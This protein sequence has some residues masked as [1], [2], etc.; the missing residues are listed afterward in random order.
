[1]AL[2]KIGEHRKR[3]CMT[4]ITVSHGEAVQHSTSYLFNSSCLSPKQ[5]TLAKGLYRCQLPPLLIWFLTSSPGPVAV[6]RSAVHAFCLDICLWRQ[7]DFCRR[8]SGFPSPSQVCVCLLD[9]AKWTAGAREGYSFLLITFVRG[10]L[11]RRDGNY[12]VGSEGLIV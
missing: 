7:K 6:S 9:L 8:F 4:V 3:C 5:Q 10:G 1:M 2:T 11:I 12:T